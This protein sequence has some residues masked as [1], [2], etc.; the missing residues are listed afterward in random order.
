MVSTKQLISASSLFSIVYLPE[1]VYWNKKKTINGTGM[2]FMFILFLSFVAASN[3]VNLTVHRNKM[4]RSS[5]VS[6]GP[7]TPIAQRGGIT[8]P[9]PVDVSEFYAVKL[10]TKATANI[11]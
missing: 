5:S 6:V 2:N 10:E 8:L 7:S 1:L 3:N 4:Q 11:E 9:L